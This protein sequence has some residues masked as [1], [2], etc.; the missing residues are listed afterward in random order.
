M[1]LWCF[2]CPSPWCPLLQLQFKMINFIQVSESN[3]VWNPSSFFQTNSCECLT[4]NWLLETP[5]TLDSLHHPGWLVPPRGVTPLF[6]PQDHSCEWHTRQSTH[7]GLP[8]YSWKLSSWNTML[9][10]PIQ[11]MKKPTGMLSQCASSSIFQH[12][13][14]VRNS[15]L[16]NTFIS[17]QANLHSETIDNKRLRQ[18]ICL[19]ICFHSPRIGDNIHKTQSSH[20]TCCE[21]I[22]WT[23]PHPHSHCQEAILTRVCILR[24][25]TI[26]AADDLQRP[27]CSKNFFL[28]TSGEDTNLVVGKRSCMM[29][30]SLGLLHII[31]FEGTSSSLAQ[32][33]SCKW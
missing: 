27:S 4:Q 6:N 21:C 20:I 1:S 29:T 13:V 31:H 22:Q 5:L 18:K 19:Y 25:G 8:H 16:A 11:T 23:W 9:N 33:D 3:I 17:A 7:S 12:V 24:K 26:P 2:R 32:V 14:R 15:S 10:H 28:R 30:K